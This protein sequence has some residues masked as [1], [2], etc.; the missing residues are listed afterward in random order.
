VRWDIRGGP[1]GLLKT[2]RL[3]PN[4]DRGSG[5]SRRLGLWCETRG[6]QTRGLVT[7]TGRGEGDKGVLDEFDPSRAAM[8]KGRGE[9]L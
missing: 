9:G 7:A 4:G 2:K 5:V 8:T 6:G 1:R 3:N